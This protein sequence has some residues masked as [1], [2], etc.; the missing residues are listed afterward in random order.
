[1]SVLMRNSRKRFDVHE[2]SVFKLDS[3]HRRVLCNHKPTS[4][5]HSTTKVDTNRSKSWS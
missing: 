5:E 2:L 3:L 1:M 4:R